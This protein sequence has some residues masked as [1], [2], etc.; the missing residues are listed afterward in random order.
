MDPLTALGLAANIVQF[1]DFTSKLLSEAHE[2]YKSGSTADHNDINLLTSDLETLAEDIRS[3]ATSST[4]N[5]AKVLPAN[6]KVCFLK[7]KAPLV[8]SDR[9]GL[10]L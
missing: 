10:N 5:A 3:G 8:K 7:W 6:E 1:V 4:I 2:R 9:V